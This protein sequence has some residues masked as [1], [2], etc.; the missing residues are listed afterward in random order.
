[1]TDWFS[2]L[3][4][5]PAV[6]GDPVQDSL[7]S[8]DTSITELKRLLGA[9]DIDLTQDP[10]GLPQAM[11]LLSY[12]DYLVQGENNE[13]SLTNI[14]NGSA[15]VL[16]QDGNTFDPTLLQQ[17]LITSGTRDAL[18][19]LAAALQAETTE[20][21]G[22]ISYFCPE[23]MTE[24]DQLVTCMEAQSQLAAV[25][26]ERAKLA[27]LAVT[28][29][30]GAF[31]IVVP[32]A[33]ATITAAGFIIFVVQTAAELVSEALPNKVGAL[34]FSI[35]KTEFFEDE[36]GTSGNWNNASVTASG[37]D[38]TLSWFT[39]VEAGLQVI[40]PFSEQLGE[41][42]QTFLPSMEQA[43]L[44][45][46]QLI[47]SATNEVLDLST[48]SDASAA[49]TWP[50][51][52]YGPVNMTD[53][54]YHNVVVNQVHVFF[55]VNDEQRQYTKSNLLPRGETS[56][57]LKL[58]SDLFAGYFPGN[59]AEGSQT[60]LLP[61]I[62]IGLDAPT[63]ASPG[64]TVQ[65]VATVD[66]A[67]DRSLNF[68]LQPNRGT[69]DMGEP[70]E[71][72]YSGTYTAPADGTLPVIVTITATHP[73][74]TERTESV[75]IRVGPE[76]EISPVSACVMPGES[77][78]FTPNVTG[79]LD[80]SV[81]WTASAGTITGSGVF[82]AP[83]SNTNLDVVISATS[84]ADPLTTDSVTI[85]TGP[86]CVCYFN[87]VVSG[88]KS[89]FFN[90]PAQVQ[91]GSDGAL[92]FTLRNRAWINGDVPNA[93]QAGFGTLPSNPVAPGSYAIGS[94]GLNFF[95]PPYSAN[96]IPGVEGAD[97]PTCGGTVTVDSVIAE[98][99][100]EGTAEVVLVRP[101]RE[102][103]EGAPDPTALLQV[104]F[105]A[106]FGSQFD[107]SSLY[108]QCSTEYGD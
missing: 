69:L 42:A 39:F 30:L 64:E 91:I 60:I 34:E 55:D 38:V 33:S 94:A 86:E 35:S 67:I 53:P 95:D 21:R 57:E 48:P 50:A 58:E 2:P 68:E 5:L 65:I 102:N 41:A 87:A 12:V 44:E 100:I 79:L 18:Q 83:E 54:Q 101:D 72:F 62:E 49:A 31:A 47:V 52:D 24:P 82:T 97:C 51:I 80:S 1:M 71:G 61:Q 88:D 23:N 76:I 45:V 36:Q 108:V 40:G 6:A 16:T 78:R 9:A 103:E 28:S 37:D 10:T 96:Y 32:P 104:E 14:M 13:N 56:W 90:G 25:V 17:M 77:L 73:S 81:M 84:I 105:R 89:A 26:S 59:K 106:A 92:N 75:E 11:R 70:N 22:A 8:M 66:K 99:T 3:I 74:I 98:Q 63:S 29:L 19:E 107:G 85:R 27:T 46:Y 43:M 20:S 7:Q 4:P 15:P 93:V